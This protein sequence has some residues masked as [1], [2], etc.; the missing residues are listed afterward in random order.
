M[1]HPTATKD[2]T[3]DSGTMMLN[4]HFRWRQKIET[5][6][7]QLATNNEQ[8]PHTPGSLYTIDTEGREC[9]VAGR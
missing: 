3:L 6:S 8:A 2:A 1:S 4:C 5:Q 9:V 7:K